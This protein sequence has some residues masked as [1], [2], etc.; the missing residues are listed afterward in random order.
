MA[1]HYNYLIFSDTFHFIHTKLSHRLE[2]RLHR[3][4]NI[5]CLAEHSR[6]HSREEIWCLSKH[7]MHF[8]VLQIILKS[9][10]CLV[11]NCILTEW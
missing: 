9:I 10:I 11:I 6:W 3:R 4:C 1:T 2:G 8:R 7:Q 5:Q